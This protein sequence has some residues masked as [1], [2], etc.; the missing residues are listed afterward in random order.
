MSNNNKMNTAT[1]RSVKISFQGTSRDVEIPAQATLAGLQAAIASTFKVDL[2][3][4]SG[5]HEAA[6]DSDLHF[7]Y[8]DPDGDNIVF[9]KDSELALA[10]RLCPTS[11]E[12]AAT[13]KEPVEVSAPRIV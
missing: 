7:A 4:R 10:I 9:D 2:P 11:L 13:G 8:K 3:D 12:I 1:S 6:K 5:A